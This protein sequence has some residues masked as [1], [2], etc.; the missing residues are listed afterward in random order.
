MLPKRLLFLLALFLSCAGP[1][2]A[3][4]MWQPYTGK[5]PPGTYV[6]PPPPKDQA[7]VPQD[8][9]ESRLVSIEKIPRPINVKHV[10]LPWSC[11]TIREAA[12]KLTQAERDMIANRYRLSKEQR[13]A[14]KECLGE[15]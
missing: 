4:L 5:G 11:A 8:R 7:R 6:E 3:G 2:A 10:P 13:L 15:R 12:K 1:A 9:I 14:V